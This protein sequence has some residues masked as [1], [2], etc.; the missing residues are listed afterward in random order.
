VLLGPQGVVSFDSEDRLGGRRSN[1]AGSGLGP[2]IAREIIQAHGG[3]LVAVS[4]P[5]AG[6]EFRGVLPITPVPPTGASSVIE[7]TAAPT[8]TLHA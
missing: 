4:D 8:P 5:E 7:V 2:A 3:S 1:A 6:T